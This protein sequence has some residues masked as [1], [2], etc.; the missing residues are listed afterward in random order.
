MDNFIFRLLATWFVAGVLA[1]APSAA[2]KS[3]DPRASDTEIKIGNIAPYSGWGHEYAAVARAEAAYFQ[4]IND[5]GGVDGRKINFI[6]VDNAS[7]TSKSLA[8][9]RK[10]IEDEKVLLIFS[11]IGTESNLAIRDY[12]NEKK[13]PQLFVESSSAV[14]DDPSHF[15]WTMGFFATYRSE[16]VAYA[17]YI[18]QTHPDAKI[19]ILYSND[20]SGKEYLAGV[21]QG[22]GD[23][24][25][26]LIIK[27]VSYQV[28]RQP[29]SAQI[30][31]LKDSG[32]D[33]LNFSVGPFR[34]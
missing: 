10:L 24:A 3:Y 2:Q 17:K 19:A 28:A 22:L 27:E 33:N 15:P 32:A 13:V 30:A 7:E 8:L 6:S 14:F 34:H 9:A 21:H 4:M 26:A 16:G 23:K 11:S 18:L 20:D 31:E 1:G 29:V 25:S 12:M 5:R